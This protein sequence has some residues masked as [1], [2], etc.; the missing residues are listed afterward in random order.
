[1][2]PSIVFVDPF[3]SVNFL[4]AQLKKA[5]I[6]L[7]VIYTICNIKKGFFALSPELFDHHFSIKKASDTDAVI[8]Q[9]K[10]LPTLAVYSGMEASLSLSDYLAYRIA[11]EYANS[12]TTSICRTSKYEMQEK[13]K[14]EGLESIEQMKV[15]QQL[16]PIQKE[17]LSTWSFPVII[18][19]SNDAGSA[20]VQSCQSIAEIEAYLKTSR[21]KNLMGKEIGFFVVQEYLEG[22]EYVVDSFSVHGKHYL[23]AVHCYRKDVYQGN[24]H[25]IYLDVIAH[26]DPVVKTMWEY[27]QNVL[28]ALGLNEGLAHSEIM[29]T[30]TGPR[31]IEVNPRISGLHGAVNSAAAYS[32]QPTQIDLLAAFYHKRTMPKAQNK[33]IYSRIVFLQNYQ[34]RKARPLNLEK[35]QT[36]ASFKEAEM[37]H[38]PGTM[39]K[40]PE[41]VV[42]TIAWLILSHPDKE[43]LWNDHLQILVWQQQGCLY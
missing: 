13:L 40:L 30:K 22:I 32:G 16:T 25:Y 34:V 15:T 28:S 14:L 26:D 36:L 4:S 19:P 29:L 35:L 8:E 21:K 42:D 41:N 24:P 31:L 38:E 39:M 43:Q 11:P 6:H 1:M 7:A 18:K 3:I 9:V 20:G 27:A 10:A 2:P 23:S 37:L 17:L 12:E 33:H 5:K